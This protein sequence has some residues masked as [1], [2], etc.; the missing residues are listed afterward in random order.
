MATQAYHDWVAAGSPWRPARPVHEL[1]AKLLAAGVPAG[2][3]GTIGDDAHLMA[4]YPQDH[5]PYSRTGWPVAHPYPLVTALDLTHAPG[6][7]GG[8]DCDEVSSYWLAEA[9][10]GRMPWA[11]YLIWRA[12]LYHARDRWVPRPNSGHHDHIHLSTRTDHITTAL[13]GWPALPGGDDDMADEGAA[14]LGILLDG[15]SPTGVQ[16]SDGGKPRVHLY[17]AIYDLTGTLAALGAK[18]DAIAARVDIDPTELAAVAEAARQGALAGVGEATDD[19]VAAI[20]TALPEGTLTRTDV[21]A[22]LRT[23][24]GSLDSATPAGG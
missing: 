4:D 1:R 23:V 9:R 12:T 5:T 3:V 6:V 21:E 16:T 20:L 13:G 10:A 2:H 14:I 19:V 24:L 22:A 11:K 8:V 7:P 17:R 15:R 18:M